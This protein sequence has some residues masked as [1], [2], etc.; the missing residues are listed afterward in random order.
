M[1]FKEERAK[2][3]LAKKSANKKAEPLQTADENLLWETRKF[4]FSGGE[5]LQNFVRYTITKGFDF[6]GS[7]RV[8]L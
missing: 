6:R 7:N 4:G 1:V 2:K 3:M 8:K 5:Q